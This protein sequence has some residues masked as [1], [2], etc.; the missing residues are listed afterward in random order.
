MIIDFIQFHTL[1][2]A[3]WRVPSQW[4][5]VSAKVDVEVMRQ[6]SQNKAPQETAPLSIPQYSSSLALLVF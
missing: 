4:G 5:L 6:M 3:V 1:F 2:P